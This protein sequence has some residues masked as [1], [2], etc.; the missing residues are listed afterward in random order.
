MH[1]RILHLPIFSALVKKAK[2]SHQ[3]RQLQ[4]HRQEMQHFVRVIQGYMAN[5]IIQVTWS[6]LQISL[7]NDVKS[8]DDLRQVHANYLHNALFR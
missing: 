2:D 5:Q 6:E 1:P 8:L 7:D 3:F 4:L